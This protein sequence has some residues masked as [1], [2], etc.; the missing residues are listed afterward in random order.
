VYV[1]V[2]DWGSQLKTERLV[3]LI[4]PAFKAYV[5]KESF[6]AAPA[7]A[8]HGQNPKLGSLHPLMMRAAQAAYQALQSSD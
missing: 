4:T 1:Y 7:Q 8:P 3:L 6:F 2:P 5:G